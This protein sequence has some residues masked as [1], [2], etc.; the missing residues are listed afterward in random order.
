MCVPSG[1]DVVRRSSPQVWGRGHAGLGVPVRETPN[2]AAL[3]RV[4]A[5]RLGTAA[6]AGEPPVTTSGRQ[7]ERDR[8]REREK[9]R[10]KDGEGGFV[11]RY[12]CSFYVLRS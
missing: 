5:P 10:E 11:F 9:G 4:T 6:C 12:V 1:M 2:G 3:Q 7:R 8:E